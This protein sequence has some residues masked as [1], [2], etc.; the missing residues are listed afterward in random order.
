MKIFIISQY[1]LPTRVAASVRVQR[2]AKVLSARHDVTI[3]CGFPTF[4]EKELAPEFRYRYYKKT[5]EGRVKIYYVH[6]PFTTKDSFFYR[7]LPQF[8]FLF[9]SFIV[10]LFLPKPDLVITTSPPLFAGLPGA[11]LGF[12]KRAKFIF[13]VR[14][15][16]PESMIVLGILKNRFFIY[17]SQKLERFIYQKAKL[18]IA[19]TPGM[20][21]ILKR[22]LP[23]KKIALL[24]NATDTVFF[25]PKNI[26]KEKYGFKKNDFVI[27]Y[28]GTINQSYNF[29][30]V[31]D[32]AKKLPSVKFLLVGD[33][34][35]KSGLQRKTKA[36]MLKNIIFHDRVSREEVLN[37]INI[38]DAGILPLRKSALIDS[39]IPAKVFEYLA[40]QKVAI[41]VGG[42]DLQN[43]IIDGRT[44][45]IVTPEDTKLL[46]PK[47]KELS[48][49]PS[50]QKKLAL[51]GYKLVNR[52]YSEKAFAK[53][54]D[55]ILKNLDD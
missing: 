18:I 4:G 34:D 29:E 5:Q 24:T 38:S 35:S 40:C 2:M 44:G 31:L 1:Y 3:I 36:H 50:L 8:A 25:Q 48:L 46:Y 42:K 6:V 54:L 22:R 17:L 30:P 45:I 19:V 32:L 27:S 53:H 28:V 51:G 7:L 37:Y 20:Q 49:N 12:F 9:S 10:G 23:Q 11:A 21:E 43:I 33:G 47:V 13:D 39:V 55:D 15:L 16:W 14:D 41:A 26:S 52:E